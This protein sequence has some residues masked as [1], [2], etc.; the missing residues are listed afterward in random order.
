MGRCAPLVGVQ[1][2]G[3][4]VNTVSETIWA[5]GDT[6]FPEVWRRPKLEA[7]CPPACT[8][9]CGSTSRVEAPDSV[10]RW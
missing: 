10:W 9:R 5:A 7:G 6:S 8:K 4:T 3:A 2:F 1:L